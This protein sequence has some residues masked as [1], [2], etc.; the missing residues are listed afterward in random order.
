MASLASSLNDQVKA[1]K[2][3]LPLTV[4]YGAP[5]LIM[6]STLAI[7]RHEIIF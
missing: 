5:D 6:K 3:S 1:G 2:N 4:S 7:G